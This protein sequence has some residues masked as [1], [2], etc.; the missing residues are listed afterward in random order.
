MGLVQDLPDHLKTMRSFQVFYLQDVHSFLCTSLSFDAISNATLFTDFFQC[1]SCLLVPAAECSS[2]RM[3]ANFLRLCRLSSYHLPACL[4]ENELEKRHIVIGI[5]TLVKIGI[6]IGK[7]ITRVW[8][9]RHRVIQSISS[10]DTNVSIAD[11]D[12]HKTQASKFTQKL[13]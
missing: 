10:T 4:S 12:V 1:W 2:S 9:H 6:I 7:K 11:T 3:L 13:R 8:R 5:S